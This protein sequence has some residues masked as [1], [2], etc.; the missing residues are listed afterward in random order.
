MLKSQKETLEA[1]LRSLEAEQERQEHELADLKELEEVS[2]LEALLHDNEPIEKRL[3]AEKAEKTVNL[4]NELEQELARKKNL[5]LPKVIDKKAIND[6]ELP[7]EQR[8][9]RHGFVICLLFNAKSP[10]EWSD[11]GVGGWRE[12]LGGTAYADQKAAE[13]R[14][15]ELKKHFPEYPLVIRKR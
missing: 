15:R 8:A 3:K 12:Q 2:R 14:L 9:V 5:P 4:E 7:E 11:E 10:S 6:I 1:R 13:E